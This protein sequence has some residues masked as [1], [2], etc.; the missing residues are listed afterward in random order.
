MPRID[1]LTPNQRRKLETIRSDATM[2]S[3]RLP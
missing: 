1:D 2:D 3:A